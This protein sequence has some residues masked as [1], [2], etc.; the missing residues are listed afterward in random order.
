MIYKYNLSENPVVN[1]S[2][3]AKILT[4]Q[5]QFGLITLWADTDTKAEQVPFE[6][7]VIL[8]EEEVPKSFVYITTLQSHKGIF[9]QHIY[10]K[11]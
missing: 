4:V 11:G 5:Q 7:V 2:R 10:L 6:F 8:T 9:V 3:N 1:L